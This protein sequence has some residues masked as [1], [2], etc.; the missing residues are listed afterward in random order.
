[1]MGSGSWSRPVFAALIVLS[2][3]LVGREASAQAGVGQDC[4][5]ADGPSCSVGL[6]CDVP[7]GQC[8]DDHAAGTCVVR[9]EVC[10]KIYK[11]VCGCDGRTYGND[12]ERIAAAA[13]KDH[14][15]ECKR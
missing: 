6:L 12:C 15:G 1:M 10:T 11:P 13:R 5:G 8:K 2:A 3:L 14:D 4:G 7:A 9:T